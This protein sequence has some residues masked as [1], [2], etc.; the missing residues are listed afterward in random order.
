V[1]CRVTHSL[2]IAG[3]LLLPSLKID[4]VLYGK[5][6]LNHTASWRLMLATTLPECKP[7]TAVTGNMFAY[8]SNPII[9][10]TVSWNNTHSVPTV[11]TRF[12]CCG[13]G[14]CSRYSNSLRGSNPRGGGIFRTRPD[15]PWGP[16][17]LLCNGYRLSPGSKAAGAWRWPPTPPSAEVK[18]RVELYSPSG[19]SWPALGWSLPLHF[20]CFNGHRNI[21]PY[22]VTGFFSDL[23]EWC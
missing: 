16:P 10:N 20:R 15:R 4:S 13:P 6:S 23:L 22:I 8:N 3:L 9:I 17:S 7:R 5:V 1:H 21:S 12:S 2:S 18:E 11:Y 14:Q 19:P